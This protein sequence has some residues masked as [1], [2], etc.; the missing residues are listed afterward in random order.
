MT[1][2]TGHRSLVVFTSL[3]IAGA[4]LVSASAY[5][6]LVHG[7]ASGRMVAAGAVLLAAGL[8]VSL[9]HLGRKGR[10]GLA[11]RG[12]GR[13]ALSHEALLAGLA[14]GA[15][16]V[17]AGLGLR[18][19]PSPIATAAAGV[20][21]TAFLVSIGLVYR[22][23]GQRT[24]RGCSAATP[25]TGGLAFGAIALQSLAVPGGVFTATLL[26]IAIDALLFSRRWRAVAGIAL[27][28]AV[29]ANPWMIRRTQLLAARF[30]LLDVM[31]LILLAVSPTFLAALVAAAGLV[32][33]RFGFY[34]LAVQHTTEYEVAAVEMQIAA[35]DPPAQR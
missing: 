12:A 21:N 11:A 2:H 31:P 10:A 14:L 9:S 28:E 13:S 5:F 19:A 24:W 23:R 35:L 7:L 33:D 34:A 8:A 4:G 22:V 25:L 20:V 16:V 32:V 18:G 26:I 27:P 30:F 1:A 6:E 15:A 3:A 17:A 29:P